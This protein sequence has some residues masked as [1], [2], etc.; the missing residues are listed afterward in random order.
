L[1]VPFV[2]INPGLCSAAVDHHFARPGN[3]F[4][5]ALC[6]AGLTPRMLRPDEDGE[7]PLWGLGMT[8]LVS[9][10]TTAASELPAEEKRRSRG[11]PPSRHCGGRVRMSGRPPEFNESTSSLFLAET[12]FL[13]VL[14]EP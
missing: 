12:G 1:V 11:S 13:P 8:D 7:L 14:P 6:E 2:G 5:T 3:R 10:A 9:R 4:W